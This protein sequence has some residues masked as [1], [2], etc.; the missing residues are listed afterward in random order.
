MGAFVWVDQ[1]GDFPVLPLDVISIGIE[2]DAQL[3]KR[4]E[5]ESTQDTIDFIDPV[6]LLHLPI[7]LL[8][9]SQIL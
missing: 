5:F 2:V 1:Q 6:L 8:Q 9:V 3:L 7:E 4:V